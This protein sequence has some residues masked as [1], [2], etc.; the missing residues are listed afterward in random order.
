MIKER[1]GVALNLYLAPKET[2]PRP[3]PALSI[4]GVGFFTVSTPGAG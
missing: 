1:G 4:P 2:F 3:P